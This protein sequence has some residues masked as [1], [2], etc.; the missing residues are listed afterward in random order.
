[1]VD[2]VE[3]PPRVERLPAGLRVSATPELIGAS[4]R[5][6][7]VTA[8]DAVDGA[9]VHGAAAV[10]GGRAVLCIAPSEGGKT[11]LCGK[12]AGRVPV[13]SD[14]TLALRLQ[15][16]LEVSGTFWWS[17]ARLPSLGGLFPLGAI[18]FLQKGGERLQPLDRPTALRALLAEWHLPAGAGAAQTAMA[19]AE[20]LLGLPFWALHTELATDPLPLLQRSLQSEVAA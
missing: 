13:L 15:P 2:L 8:L 3:G 18:C 7:L 19:R 6:L 16:A 5:G 4:L 9:L 12:L 20:R 14:E 10:L 17:G 1:M 11:T